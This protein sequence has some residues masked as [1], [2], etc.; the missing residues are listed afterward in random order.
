[1]TGPDPDGRHEMEEAVRLRQERREL[2]ETQGERPIWMNLS[3]TG[4]LGWL[5]V[6]PTLAGVAVGRWLDAHFATGVTFTG[7]AIVAGVAF[8]F[9]LAWKR[10]NRE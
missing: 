3:M 8:G 10:M 2:W 4:A 1:M 9:Y 7:A 6:L 5:I